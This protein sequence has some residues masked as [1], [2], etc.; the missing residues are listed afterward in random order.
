VIFNWL[1]AEFLL[2][3]PPCG[4]WALASPSASFAAGANPA[5]AASSPR[6]LNRVF[7]R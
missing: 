2:K 6:R 5:P 3:P 1:G 4:A 7:C